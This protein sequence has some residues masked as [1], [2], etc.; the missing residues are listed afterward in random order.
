MLPSSLEDCSELLPTSPP[1]EPE[2]PPAEEQASPE[3]DDSGEQFGGIAATE[4]PESESTG[5][6]Q[7]SPEDA[8]DA[9]D[10]HQPDA[11]H[12]PDQASPDAADDHQ[13]DADNTSDQA[14]PDL[15]L[16]D[17]TE[18]LESFWE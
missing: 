2:A 7:G 10:D 16:S 15:L 5:D 1:P 4:L 17:D 11:N 8:S 6:S 12:T 3:P 13:L 9:A 18:G 14:S